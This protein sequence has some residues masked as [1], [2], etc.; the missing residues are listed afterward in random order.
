MPRSSDT[1]TLT[2]V[3]IGEDSASGEAVRVLIEDEWHWVPYSQIS[4]TIRTKTKGTDSI[5]IAAWLARKNE[6]AE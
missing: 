3:T 2:G 4:K 1:V 6:W 5:T